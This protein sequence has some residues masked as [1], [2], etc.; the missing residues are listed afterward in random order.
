M[1]S[2]VL[3]VINFSACEV[4]LCPMTAKR[5]VALE[6]VTIARDRGSGVIGVLGQGSL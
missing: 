5:V 4:F 1:I 6:I 3:G 2:L